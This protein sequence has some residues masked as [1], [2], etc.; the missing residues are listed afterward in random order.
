[1][2]EREGD[3]RFLENRN[4]RLRQIVRQGTQAR[5]QPSAQNKGLSDHLLAN[6]AV[7]P[8]ALV[9]RRHSGKT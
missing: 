7:V 2:V 8:P 9:L 6:G 5:A 4:E 3:E 1:M